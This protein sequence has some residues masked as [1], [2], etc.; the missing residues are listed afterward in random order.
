MATFTNK[1]TLSYNGLTVA[2]NTVTGEIAE[3][4]EISKTA[5]SETYGEDPVTYAV[6]FVN[7]GASA[8]TGLTMTDDLGAYTVGEQTVYPLS[9][10]AGTVRYFVNGVLQPEPA[11]TATAG[12]T[13]EGLSLPAGGSAVLVYEAAPTQFAPPEAG[14]QIVNTATVS[15]AG[16]ASPVSAQ[17][18]I[19]AEEAPRLAIFKSVSPAEVTDNGV[20]TYTFVI[21]NR[22]NAAADASAGIVVSDLF[23]PLLQDLNVMMDGAPMPRATGYVYDESTGQFDTVAGVITV[24]AAQI[25]QDPATGAYTV[26]PGSATLIVSGTV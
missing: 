16:I 19:A 24:P 11:V 4:L 18:T 7:S 1:A 10:V 22:G 13:V 26:Q 8:L 17:E 15:G 23:D 12:L 2:S 21:E 3:V 5:L 6:A 20:L 9:Y 14:G 25:S